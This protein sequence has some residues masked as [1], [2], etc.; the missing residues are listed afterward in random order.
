MPNLNKCARLEKAKINTALE[1]RGNYEYACRDTMRLCIGVMKHVFIWVVGVGTV[2]S[3]L[4]H[5]EYPT[6]ICRLNTNCAA[7]FN[8]YHWLSYWSQC[9][10]IL[11]ILV[12]SS[13]LG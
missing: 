4:E 8:K 2:M 10:I 1:V 11:S 6:A 7:N 13:K 9:K 12:L 3:V 5:V